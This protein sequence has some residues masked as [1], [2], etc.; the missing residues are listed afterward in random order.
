MDELKRLFQL[1]E[2][3]GFGDW[4]VF[5]ASVV[6]GLAYYTGVVFEG[7]DRAGELRAICGGGR[8]DRLL[9]LYGA[10][11]EV[12]ACGFGFG[13]CVVVELLKDK[14]ILPNL[15]KS[16][17]FVV[18]AFNESMQ[19]AAM[20]TT[21]LMRDGG[22][23]VDLLLEPKK[24]VANTFDYANRAGARYIVFVA[25]SEWEKGTVRIKDL[26]LGRRP[27]TR[28]NRSTSNWRISEGSERCSTRGRSREAWG[29]WPCERRRRGTDITPSA[30][31][32]DT[33]A[34]RQLYLRRYFGTRL[35]NL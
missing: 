31:A 5:D 10:V 21:A 4:L 3:Y 15:P 6:R 18:A 1:A 25:P 20:K 12:P 30:E 16:V 22:A 9:S 27:R 14:G 8:Y 23:K 34:T 24:K 17:D 13:D 28:R 7:F 26:R 29:R 11:T 33:D 35:K 2:D 32:N 19:G